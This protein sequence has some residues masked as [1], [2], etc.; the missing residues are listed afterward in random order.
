ML[1][2]ITENNL[3]E[4]LEKAITVLNNGGII[5][6]PTE[7]FY[8]LGAKFDSDEALKRLYELK[9]RDKDKPIPLIIGN[10]QLLF[11]LTDTVSDT[12]ELLIKKFW[13]GP[14]TLIFKAKESLSGY[15]TAK[16]GK[17]AVRIPGE[18]IAL[19]FAESAGFPITTTS[20][21]ISGSKPT[22]SADE[23]IGLFGG[24][25]DLVIDGGKTP[26]S[27]PSTIVDVSG[28]NLEILREG[29]I[30]ESVIRKFLSSSKI[31]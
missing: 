23:V 31:R 27:M 11:S 6:Y 1:V 21:N 3:K 18:S 20:A 22:E 9:S 13:P 5:A 16:T 12:A 4:V 17:V 15:I 28:K 2:R 14:L 8:G 19:R 29:A 30:P 10:K 26:S 24:K 25:I 7:T